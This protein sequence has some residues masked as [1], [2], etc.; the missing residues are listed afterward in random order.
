MVVVLL[1]LICGFFG[2]VVLGGSSFGLDNE[3]LDVKDLVLDDD[4]FFGDLL[5]VYFLCRWLLDD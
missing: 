4:Y 1:L 5:F 2:L 3:R